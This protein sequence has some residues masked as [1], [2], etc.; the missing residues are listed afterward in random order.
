MELVTTNLSKLS[1]D[2]NNSI[3]AYGKG[4][5]SKV[6]FAEAVIKIRAAFPKLKNG[7]FNILES[8]LKNDD[9]TEKRLDDAI[10]NLVKTFKYPEPTLANILSYDKKVL[11]FTYQE[12]LEMSKDMSP[13]GRINFMGQYRYSK[14]KKDA[15][16]HPM[17]W[18]FE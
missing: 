9:W 16:G 8:E 11:F 12:I 3:S 6:K 17:R 15:Q 2:T 7:F 10:D 13:E 4:E 1:K 14:T 5:I 18:R